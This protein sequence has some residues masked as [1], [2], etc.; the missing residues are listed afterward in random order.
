MILS[1]EL[2]SNGRLHK[3]RERGQDVDRGVDLLVVELS[4]DEDLA[5]CDIA[6]QI[7]D[8]VGDI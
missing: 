6:S 1:S 8:R 3:T 5:L 4:I 2:L 7:R